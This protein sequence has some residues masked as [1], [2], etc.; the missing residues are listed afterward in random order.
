MDHRDDS[1]LVFDSEDREYCPCEDCRGG[2]LA[3][4]AGALH[5]LSDPQEMLIVRNN[6]LPMN[7]YKALTVWPFIFV[8]S[9]LSDVD[10]NHEK[11]HGR[12]QAE[13]LIVIFL[14]LYVIEW[15]V[16]LIQYRDGH[17]A[18]KNISLEREAYGNED[19]SD[20]LAHRRLFAWTKYL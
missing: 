9:E 4:Y 2:Y 19:K 8:S 12:Q 6:F 20:Y 7:G 5:H 3:T 13:M 16:R 18:Y 11:I 17:K 14:L 10:M 15:L 1:R